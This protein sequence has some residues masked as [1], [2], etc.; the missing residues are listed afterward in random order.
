MPKKITFTMQNAKYLILNPQKWFFEKNELHNYSQLIIMHTCGDI[1][2]L[3]YV[4]INSC[5]LNM[6][7]Q[8]I[9]YIKRNSVCLSVCL[10]VYVSVCFNSFETTRGT[11]IKLGTIDHHPVVS[12]IKELVTSR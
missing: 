7:K 5:Q 2:L 8:F 3:T 9:Q 12:V 6:P 10:S 4:I 11:T 1:S